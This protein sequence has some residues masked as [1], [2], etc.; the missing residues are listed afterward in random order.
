M[1]VEAGGVLALAPHITTSPTASIAQLFSSAGGLFTR[2]FTSP[3]YYTPG[4]S[5]IGQ[6]LQYFTAIFA[7]G[8]GTVSLATQSTTITV[9]CTPNSPLL[10]AA[11]TGHGCVM[12]PENTGYNDSSNC[13][14]TGWCAY[15]TGTTFYNTNLY[16]C[17]QCTPGDLTFCPGATECQ[18]S[19]CDSNGNC[20]L[21]NKASDTLCN[22]GAG[23]CD[24]QGR[25]SGCTSSVCRRNNYNESDLTMVDISGCTN[26]TKNT[27]IL[28]NFACNGDTCTD[29]PTTIITYV[30]LS[31][32]VGTN[33]SIS[34]PDDGQCIKSTSGE[35]IVCQAY[36]CTRN[37]QCVDPTGCTIAH[38]NTDTHNC[39]N[40][41]NPLACNDTSE[42]GLVNWDSLLSTCVGE[43]ALCDKIC[44]RS[45]K[46]LDHACTQNGTAGLCKGTALCIP[47]CPTTTT[48]GC[49]LPNPNPAGANMEDTGK[50]CPGNNVC[51]ACKQG[52]FY[53]RDSNS[54]FPSQYN[55][56]FTVSNAVATE[57]I[58]VTADLRD[59]GYQP[60][61]GFAFRLTLEQ[62][63]Q[64][65]DLYS[66]GTFIFNRADP[67]IISATLTATDRNG[68]AVAQ[69][70]KDIIV[71][72]PNNNACCKPDNAYYESDNAQCVR[73]NIPGTC[74]GHTC[75]LS[76][77][78]Q[79]T[80]ETSKDDRGRDRCNNG[81]DDDCNGLYDCN[82]PACAGLSLCRTKCS[83][84]NII[85]GDSCTDAMTSNKHCGGCNNPCRPDEQC[86]QGAC[87]AVEE[88]QIVCNVDRDCRAGEVCVNPG[89]CK[90]SWCAP[91]NV[92]A[93]NQSVVDDLTQ[94]IGD[95]K[96]YRIEKQVYGSR[97]QIKIINLMPVPLQNVT[98]VVNINLP[99]DL[100]ASAS[101]LAADHPFE[102]IKDDPIIAFSF[103]QIE[104]SETIMIELP[105]SVDAGMVDSISASATHNPV[106]G[107]ADPL[108][109]DQIT[110]TSNIVKSG[111]KS[112]LVI[113]LDPHS[114]LGGV[115]V[116][117]QIPKCMVASIKGLNMT[118]DYE[119]IKD[120]PLVV[121]TFDSLTAKQAIEIDL[122]SKDVSEDCKNSLNAFAVASTV[123]RPINPWLP[124]LLIP[125]IGVIIIFFQRF[126]AD[127]VQERLS[128]V[129]FER[130]GREEGRKPEEI[131]EAW[132]EYQRRF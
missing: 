3:L 73:N 70:V 12:S 37:D 23:W 56:D 33:C 24:G 114:K 79:A 1:S 108:G 82:D 42:L 94:Q 66:D 84:G 53:V 131:E 110:I 18:T 121:W 20:V 89:D 123:R 74:Q 13:C 119:I 85:C 22:G 104:A 4:I 32:P 93:A 39:L 40:N 115:R 60:V 59:G 109:Q 130:L 106:S 31:L 47:T 92:V 83:S 116:P 29:A 88:C 17:T 34:Q 132:G 87:T 67:G 57:D 90:N 105:R 80:S 118:G 77:M 25:C 81:I 16:R 113:G 6:S 43:A 71:R 45:A 95:S 35:T 111:D 76:C 107:T 122:G 55:L 41:P 91:A 7:R 126:R 112:K 54:C 10:C 27:T 58:T 50:S 48:P 9:T 124:L 52:Y 75:M 68:K 46:I 99:K 28:H 69:R 49:L 120:D 129:E 96:T 86:L 51:Y 15:C 117:V 64:P 38:C 97:V 78:P 127:D 21:D 128:K 65:S 102:T 11:A 98:V 14:T 8:D 62:N 36:R 61:P 2:T 26:I 101:E 30:N 100:L 72:C 103:P 125:I 5:Q 44:D 63:G 19:A